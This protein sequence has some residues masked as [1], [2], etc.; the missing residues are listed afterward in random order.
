[1]ISIESNPITQHMLFIFA[2]G[3]S[4]VSLLIPLGHDWQKQAW[5]D[6]KRV[7]VQQAGLTHGDERRPARE[8]MTPSTFTCLGV[9]L[10]PDVSSSFE[11]LQFGTQQVSAIV[12]SSKSNGIPYER[13]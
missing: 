7:T 2:L 13:F 3:V 1:M 10:F 11:F 4:Y 9:V 12:H 5:S 6:Q 8:R